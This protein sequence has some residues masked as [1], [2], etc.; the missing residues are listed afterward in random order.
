MPKSR[1]FFL[2]QDTVNETSNETIKFQDRFATKEV[3]DQITALPQNSDG[4]I[5]SVDLRIL[6]EKNVTLAKSK[7]LQMTSRSDANERPILRDEDLTVCEKGVLIGK[8]GLCSAIHTFLIWETLLGI[9]NSNAAANFFLTN[10]ENKTLWENISGQILWAMKIELV[11]SGL[12][13]LIQAMSQSGNLLA[14]YIRDERLLKSLQES[15]DVYELV[16]MI[17]NLVGLEDAVKGK[18]KDKIGNSSTNFNLAGVGTSR[19]STAGRLTDNYF[20]QTANST[21]YSLSNAY[22]SRVENGEYRAIAAG[23]AISLKAINTIVNFAIQTSIPNFLEDGVAGFVERIGGGFTPVSLATAGVQGVIKAINTWKLLTLDRV[24][25]IGVQERNWVSEV[26]NQALQE[27]SQYTSREYFFSLGNQALF[28]V[29]GRLLFEFTIKESFLNINH[30]QAMSLYEGLRAGIG[31]HG[32]KCVGHSLFNL[33][34]KQCKTLPKNINLGFNKFRDDVRGK[35]KSIDGMTNHLIQE[36]NSNESSLGASA[37]QIRSNLL[38][39]LT[40]AK[41]EFLNIL[42]IIA[43]KEQKYRHKPQNQPINED[44]IGN[45]QIGILELIGAF[46]EASEILE[47]TRKTASIIHEQQKGKNMTGALQISFKEI[48]SDFNE[49]E[50][51]ETIGV[52]DNSQAVDGPGIEMISLNSNN[53]SNPVNHNQPVSPTLNLSELSATQTLRNGNIAPNNFPHATYCNVSEI[54]ET[55]LKKKGGCIRK[56]SPQESGGGYITT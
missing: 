19:F 45:L 33:I 55:P 28:R 41:R 35:I 36:I 42:K 49:Q 29:F 1:T 16:E 2:K 26:G 24:F 52:A 51:S 20:N 30:K 3:M 25:H 6:T 50:L 4:E 8:S 48:F 32:S 44:E 27:L 38:V 43:Q 5:S 56:V 53:I 12:A 46:A 17:E 10:F 47:N 13:P 11:V 9:L 7:L 34:S 21:H 40:N 54:R 39:S 14:H 23:K 37:I 31:M 18:I 15:K 22:S